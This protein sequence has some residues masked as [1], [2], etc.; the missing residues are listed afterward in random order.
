MVRKSTLR[1]GKF[2]S[3]D[4]VSPEADRITFG[5]FEWLYLVQY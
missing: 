1:L 4:G 5:V 2:S 3:P